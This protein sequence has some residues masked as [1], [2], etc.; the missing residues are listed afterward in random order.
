MNIERQNINHRMSQVV[1]FNGVVHLAGQVASGNPGAPVQDQTRNV[2]KNID[3]LLASANTDKSKL[4]SATIWLAD[5]SDFH[6][7]NEVWDAWISPGNAP[8]RACVEGR[9]ASPDYIVEIQVTA[10]Q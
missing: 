8:V 10:A 9:L 6:A 5:I 7:M 3:T 4:I 1:K 2:L